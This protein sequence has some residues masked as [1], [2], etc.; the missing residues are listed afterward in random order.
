ME[1]KGQRVELDIQHRSVRGWTV[2]TVIGELDLHTSPSLHDEISSA[3]AAGAR[4]VAVDLSGVGFMDSTALG[5]LVSASATAKDHGAEL[6]LVGVTGSPARVLA[7]TGMDDVFQ[8][9]DH[10]EELP[11]H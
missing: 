7:L 8:T 10:I 4:S 3:I 1:R 2:I 5:V 11:N 9:V 6:C